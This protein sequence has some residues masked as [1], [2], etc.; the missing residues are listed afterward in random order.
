MGWKDDPEIQK[1]TSLFQAAE[2]DRL[3][4]IDVHARVNL[5]MGLQVAVRDRDPAVLLRT[6]DFNVRGLAR[7][8]R[9]LAFMLQVYKSATGI[10]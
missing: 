3:R 5:L 7:N 4:G 6:V 8:T 2:D 9:A 10:T 1:A